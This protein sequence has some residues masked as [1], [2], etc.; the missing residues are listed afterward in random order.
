MYC[1]GSNN[2]DCCNNHEGSYAFQGVPINATGLDNGHGTKVPAAGIAG[3]V[4]GVIGIISLGICVALLLRL[5]K[6]RR[7]KQD[8]RREQES[9]YLHEQMAPNPTA[10]EHSLHSHPSTSSRGVYPS[11]TLQ[12]KP[13]VQ[14]HHVAEKRLPELPKEVY[15]MGG[16]GVAR[17]EV[18]GNGVYKDDKKHGYW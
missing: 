4:V 3:I 10:R 9:I 6:E 13:S 14:S 17:Y 18:S 12:S 15:E 2:T 5:R 7:P 1:C 11:A 16:D 8:K